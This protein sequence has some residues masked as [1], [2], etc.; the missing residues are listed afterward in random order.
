MRNQCSV[1]FLR[2]SQ[3]IVD[4]ISAIENKDKTRLIMLA[5]NLSEDVDSF[6]GESFVL[7]GVKDEEIEALSPSEEEEIQLL[8]DAASADSIR[9]ASVKQV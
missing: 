5:G 1:A 4:M 8:K 6:I 9:T 2:I 7:A 3:L